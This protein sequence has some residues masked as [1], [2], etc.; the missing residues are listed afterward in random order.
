MNARLALALS[1][2]ALLSACGMHAPI[3]Q[4]ST[5]PSERPGLGTVW[6]ENRESRTRRVSFERAGEQPF[7]VASIHYDDRD[8]V[9]EMAARDRLAEWRPNGQIPLRA[10]LVAAVVD[11]EG[12]P[13]PSLITGERAYVVGSAGDRYSLV[14]ENQTDRRCE[15]VASVDGLDVIDGERAQIDKRGY[16]I[17]PHQRLVIDGFRRSDSVVAAFR[18]GTVADSYAARSGLERDVG[19]IGFAFFAERA[20]DEVDLRKTARPFASLD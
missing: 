11:G 2:G 19:V 13:L 3:S 16:V 9:Q 14:V 12:V 1:L 20:D 4:H 17:P 18:F 5:T 7:A 8:G 10:G 6:G 15:V